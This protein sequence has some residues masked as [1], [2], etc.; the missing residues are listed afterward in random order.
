MDELAGRTKID[1]YDCNK[2]QPVIKI[3]IKKEGVDAS[4]G[5]DEPAFISGKDWYYSELH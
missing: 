1:I 4:V 2:H 3:G 5:T